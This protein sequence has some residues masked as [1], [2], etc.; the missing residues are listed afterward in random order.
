MEKNLPIIVCVMR[1]QTSP[2]I[3]KCPKNFFTKILK[4]SN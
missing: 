4:N 2:I 3:T 1:D